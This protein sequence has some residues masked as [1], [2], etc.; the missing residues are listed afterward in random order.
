MR[1]TIIDHIIKNGNPAG[2]MGND[3]CVISA[4]SDRIWQVEDRCLKLSFIHR[5]LTS[6]SVSYTRAV[7]WSPDSSCRIKAGFFFF[8]IYSGDSCKLLFHCVLW[9]FFL[10]LLAMITGT[11]ILKFYVVLS[12]GKFL[13]L[14]HLSNGDCGRYHAQHLIHAW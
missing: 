12:S 1:K 7:V 5:Y 2:Q 14:S 6:A 10:P 8:F 11:R 9:I 13:L 3:S 4:E